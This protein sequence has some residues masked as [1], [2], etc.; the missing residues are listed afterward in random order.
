MAKILTVVVPT[1][2]MEQYLDEC[3]HSL[4]TEK[5]DR[6]IQLLMGTVK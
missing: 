6:L 2:N 5:S 1:Y 3:L 4:I